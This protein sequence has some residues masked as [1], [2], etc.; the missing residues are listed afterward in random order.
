MPLTDEEEQ[1]SLASAPQT[2]DFCSQ[3]GQWGSTK[4]VLGEPRETRARRDLHLCRTAGNEA[5]LYHRQQSRDNLVT[6]GEVNLGINRLMEKG[7]L[8]QT[9]NTKYH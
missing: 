5:I 7:C 8:K 1:N 9:K 4:E 6:T 3:K 2:H